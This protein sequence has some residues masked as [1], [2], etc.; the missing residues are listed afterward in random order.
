MSETRLLPAAVQRAALRWLVGLGLAAWLVIFLSLA[1]PLRREQTQGGRAKPVEA[2][3]VMCRQGPWGD[4]SY[5]RAVLTPPDSFVSAWVGNPPAVVWFFKKLSRPEVERRLRELNLNPADLASLLGSK[6]VDEAD[7]I[8]VHPDAKLVM[9]LGGDSRARLYR[10][11]AESPRNQAQHDPFTL[12]ADR[13]DAWL[14]SAGL[15]EATVS[16]LR[17]LFYP[18]GEYMCFSDFETVLAACPAP[19]ERRTLVR[20]WSEC[21]AVL[22]RLSVDASTDLTTLQFYWT[23]GAKAK[24]VLPLLQSLAQAPGGATLDL[25][26][27]LTPYRRRL[28]YSWSPAAH[29]SARLSPESFWMAANFPHAIPAEDADEPEALLKV[30]RDDYYAVLSRPALGDV[31]VVISGKD[32]YVH[33]CVQIADDIV[34]T[35]F[36]GCFPTPWV[37]MPLPELLDAHAIHAPLQVRFFRR[38]EP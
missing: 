13:L 20:K 10:L 26:H 22:P 23:R 24:D 16:T 30:I 12:R 3:A 32:R 31:G 1:A 7:G 17:R 29:D 5:I 37:F 25:A 36:P 2:G 33:T 15:S 35:Q 6:W 14:S 27:L 8:S 34:F 18:C 28:L 38:K 21:R 9:E 19:E 4:V 11:L